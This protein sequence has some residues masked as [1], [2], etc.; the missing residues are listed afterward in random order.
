MKRAIA[1]GI[2]SCL[3]GLTLVGIAMY[4]EMRYTQNGTFLRDWA[5]RGTPDPRYGDPLDFMGK[6]VRIHQFVILPAAS[7]VVGFMV[8]LLVRR[9]L[10]LALL[11][12][13][14]PLSAMVSPA[15]IGSVFSTLICILLAWLGARLGQK[16]IANGQAIAN[17]T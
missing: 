5:V 8:G 2:C 16:R 4:L 6:W 13:I 17:L 1:V 7:F 9:G 14:C 3:F 10:V 11:I 12:G 15:D